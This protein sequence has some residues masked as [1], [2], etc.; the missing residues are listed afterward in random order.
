MTIRHVLLIVALLAWAT[1][2]KEDVV[3]PTA[4]GTFGDDVAFLREH[5]GTVVLEQGPARVAVVPAWQGRVMTSTSGGDAAPGYGWINRD[6]I[7]RGEFQ[8]HM[9]AFGGEDRFWMGPEGGQF[10]IFFE[11]EAP[12]DL[13]HWQTP[14]SIDTE[15]YE[16]VTAGS[17]KAEFRH[18]IHLENYS[19]TTF[20]LRVDRSIR[21]ISPGELR[22]LLDLESEAG[23]RSVAFESSNRL[24]NTGRLPWTKESGLLSIWI[25]GQFNPSPETTVIIPFRGGIGADSQKAVVNDAYFGEVPADRLLIRPGVIFF[26]ADGQFRSKIGLSVER[27]RSVLGS[28]DRANQVLTIVQ[29][30]RPEGPADYVNSMWEIQK[31]PFAGDVVNSYNDGAPAPGQAPLGPFYEL[32]TSSPAAA[33]SPGGSTEHVHRTIHLT[34]D[35]AALDRV[36]RRILGVSLDAAPW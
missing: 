35:R 29:L 16:L 15:P 31:E 14:P 9:N 19:G 13:D 18:D 11:P 4:G 33:L 1:G 22:T 28:W 6:L 32:E 26:R 36:A 34:G 20:D 25:L 7:A 27:A 8:P 2:C 10:S 24:T 3:K 17:D 21:M 30:T 12:F 5:A 23:I